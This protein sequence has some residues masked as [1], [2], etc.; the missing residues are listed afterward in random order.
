MKYKQ[1]KQKDCAADAERGMLA[2]GVPPLVAAVLCARG[3]D[4]V[5]KAEAFLASDVSRLGDPF[6]LQ[7]M[8]RAVLRVRQALSSGERIA[9]FGDYD[10]DGIT[11][12]CLLTHWLRGQGGDVF[13]YIPDRIEEGYGLSHEALLFLHGQGVS[14][15]IT[16]DCG[17]TAVDETEYAKSLGIELVI[18]DHHECREILPDA[19]AVVNPRRKGSEYPL[20]CLAG[21]GVA[22]KLVLALGGQENQGQLL[23][24]YA[25]LVAVGT[26]ADVMPLLQ[27]NRT[28][29]CMGLAEMRREL[30]PG[31][32]ALLRLAGAEGKPVSA[33]T[34]G[35]LLAPRLN[36]AGRMG[37]A[38]VAAELL[39]TGDPVR[40]E[41]LAGTLCALN[42][43]RQ[44]VEGEIYSACVEA[45]EREEPRKRRAVVMAGDGWH[46]GVVGIVASRMSEKY[47]C[48]AFMIS[49]QGGSGKGSCRSYGGFNLY[50]ALEHCAEL[51]EGF[52]G[53][54]LAAG[55]SIREENIPVFRTRMEDYVN[56]CTDGEGMQS[57]LEID[58]EIDDPAL[59]T[60]ENVESLSVLEPFGT[61]N[62][63]PVFSLQGATISC[64]A[65]VGGGKHL[66]MRLCRDGVTLDGIFFSA[67]TCQGE[68]N[69]G[70]KVDLAFFPSMNEFRGN[71][72][73]QLQVTDI[74]PA[75]T[76]AQTEQI[77]YEKL[78]RGETL[79][80]RQARILLPS[81]EEFI[82]LWRFLKRNAM[83]NQLE[84]T[85]CSLTR[86]VSRTYGLR[87][88]ATRTMVCLEVLEECGLIEFCCVSDRV[89]I[90]VLPAVQKVDLE[91]SR[92]MRKLRA[93]TA[94]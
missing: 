15:V 31:L 80:P 26:V 55:F 60:R 71:C 68:L 51:L 41:E 56:A 9:V 65:A 77:L 70:D 38:S 37:C 16:V 67:G 39:L 43:E 20:D 46:Q 36:A 63:R 69:V 27:E 73:V 82:G 35:F 29:V 88:T 64:L 32:H 1:W 18:T 21:V 81:R 59:L 6:L 62:A 61:G 53:H 84:E 66:K 11:S 4:T 50:E 28:L 19:Q 44:A 12:T 13:Y 57:V 34:I 49:L 45:L 92:V 10:V 2:R 8:D 47:A 40:A 76:R 22:L 89:R 14:L 74:R 85:V 5:E 25:D 75:L 78:R 52:G 48:P 54:A 93:M 23:R 94:Q 42:R 58:V 83:E 33:C 79:S 7:D 3:L 91:Q 24:E 30:R 86:C 72:T 17:I 90:Q 87:E